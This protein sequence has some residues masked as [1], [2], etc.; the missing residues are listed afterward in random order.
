MPIT[1][2]ATTTAMPTQRS[3][4]IMK[5][6]R[7]TV[8]TAIISKKSVLSRRARSRTVSRCC[9]CCSRQMRTPQRRPTR[10]RTVTVT[11]ANFTRGRF[12]TKPNKSQHATRTYSKCLVGRRAVTKRSTEWRNCLRRDSCCMFAVRLTAQ[13]S[14]ASRASR[15][16]QIRIPAA[17][18]LAAATLC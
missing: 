11:D 4:R 7:K 1:A 2:N 15:T 5:A 9:C 8:I 17:R 10:I 12:A 18:G 3:P 6:P 13:R 16:L 14:A